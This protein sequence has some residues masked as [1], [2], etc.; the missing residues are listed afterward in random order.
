MAL[1]DSPRS[2]VSASVF[3]ASV[4]LL[5][6]ASTLYHFWPKDSGL[7]PVLRRLDHATIFLFIAGVYTPFALKLFGD[8]WGISILSTVWALAGMGWLLTVARPSTPR[9]VRILLYL[10]LGWIS[11]ATIPKLVTGVPWQVLAGVAAG[12]LMYSFG[13]LIYGMKRPNPLPKYFGY[14]E[15]FHLLVVVATGLFYWVIARYIL[16]L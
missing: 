11:V 8:A 13:A 3:G 6:G 7:R 1:S 14:H 16:P 10:A 5:F 4:I 15:V 9:W 12:G 2:L